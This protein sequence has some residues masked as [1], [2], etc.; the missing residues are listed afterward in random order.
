MQNNSV[1]QK[2]GPDY[3]E[4]TVGTIANLATVKPLMLEC[5]KEISNF[6]I[7]YRTYGDL[8]EDKSN[9]VLV[10]H[11]LTGD[12]YLAEKNPI[13]GKSGWWEKVVG[14]GKIYDTDK[15]F[16]ICINVL[17]GCSGSFGPKSINPKN[18]KHYNL[19]F[20]VITIKDI[21]NTQKLLLDYLGIKQLFMVV[22]ASMGGM[23]AMQLATSY[24]KIVK[25]CV[26]I[27][28]AARHTAQNI[29]FNEIGRQA[30]IADSNWCSG[31]YLDEKKFPI[32][33][34]SVARMM[35]H[36]TYLSEKGLENKFGRDL[37]DREDITFGFD[38]DFQI[39]SYLRHQ[40][41]SFVD[42][43]DPNSYLYITRAMDYFDLYS[44]VKGNLGNLFTNSST[45]FLVISFSSD[46]LFTTEES[47]KIV[48]A[49]SNARA[50]VSFVEVQT[51]KGHDAFLLDEPEF[52]SI[53]QGYVENLT[54]N[55][56]LS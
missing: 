26:V 19:D 51:D 16:V 53:L 17:G 46:W 48:H 2:F 15:Y 11:G 4:A 36:V 47:K 54:D 33:G 39:E 49:L 40:G 20:P 5:G 45:N 27:A 56:A 22:G 14:K 37:Q 31:N 6:P 29:A 30:I 50:R 3:K 35:A 32:K 55:E 43:F 44:Q 41:V 1:T 7:A 10:C 24:P 42:R 23:V 8:N 38:A 52:F 21:A 18:G 9:V 25:S 13:T 28:A 12:Q 34:L